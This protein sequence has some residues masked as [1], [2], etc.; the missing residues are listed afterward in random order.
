MSLASLFGDD[1]HTATQDAYTRAMKARKWVVLG[2]A[3]F[4]AVHAR[5]FSPGA[6]TVGVGEM[7]V[8][9]P[10]WSVLTGAGLIYIAVQYALLN[11]Q[12][13]VRYQD[14]LTHRFGLRE[15]ERRFRMQDEIVDLLAQREKS[16]NQ[17]GLMTGSVLSDTTAL[18]MIDQRVAEL[19]KQLEAMPEQAKPGPIYMGSEI[20]IDALRLVTP[21][22]GVALAAAAASYEFP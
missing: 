13:A 17:R 21:W 2:A 3:A 4:Y 11:L 22:A 16:A 19:K 14:L 6:F 20:I 10:A 12:L 1:E 8:G 5:Q 18:T 7:E 9:L 15:L